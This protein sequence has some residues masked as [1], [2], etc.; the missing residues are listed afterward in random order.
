[1]ESIKELRKICQATRESPIY[2]MNWFDRNFLRKLSIFFS[3]GFIKAG[4]TANQVTALD[5]FF[6]IVS[7]M[8]F[9]LADSWGW[10]IGIL[11]FVLYLI[12][13]CSDGEVARY[14]LYKGRKTNRPFGVGAILGG[15][16]DWFVWSYMFAC[17]SFGIYQATHNIWVFAF[18]FLAIIMRYLYQDIG[19]MP[20]PILHEKGIL[21]EVVASGGKPKESKIMGLGRLFF[22]VQGFLPLMLTV[23]IVDIFIP[24][25]GYMPHSIGFVDTSVSGFLVNA[26]FIYLAIFG[27]GALCGVL[28]KV[29]DVYKNGA[30]IQRI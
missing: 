18:G 24:V 17:M 27:L 9:A 26:R 28:V 2:Q 10:L 1:V 3:K 30:R 23:I 12:I 14:W 7:G 13:D 4:Y 25:F 16:V 22:G 29:R 8:Y 6:V 19:L 21:N 11:C 15:I 5:F 20:Y